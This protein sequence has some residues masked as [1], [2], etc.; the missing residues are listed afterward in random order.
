MTSSHI[1]KMIRYYRKESGLSQKDFAKIAGI[2]KTAL[3][4]IETAILE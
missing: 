2:G 4:D 1:A 3:F